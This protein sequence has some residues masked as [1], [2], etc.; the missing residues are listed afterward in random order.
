MLGL[1]LLG[2]SYTYISHVCC[3]GMQL[4]YLLFRF[5]LV[6]LFRSWPWAFRGIH[7]SRRFG[8]LGLNGNF[9]TNV[10]KA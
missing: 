1:L 9:I 7:Q 5:L 4:S 2:H 3:V 8:L 10:Q 6:F